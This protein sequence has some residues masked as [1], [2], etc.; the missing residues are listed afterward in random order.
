[1]K[2]ESVLGRGNS[3][4]KGL[5]MKEAIFIPLFTFPRVSPADSFGEAREAALRV[6]SVATLLIN[7]WDK[8]F[9]PEPVSSSGKWDS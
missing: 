2:G 9:I 6:Q 8:S 1:M 5:V 3:L 7:D 4:C